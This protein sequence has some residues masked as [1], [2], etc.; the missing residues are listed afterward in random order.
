[1]TPLFKNRQNS[2]PKAPF[3]STLNWRDL[4]LFAP[5]A[6]AMT[7]MWW[8]PEGDKYAPA[9]ILAILVYFLVSRSWKAITGETQQ[10]LK[11]P[12]AATVIITALICAAGY[13]LKGG[14][15]SE[16]RTLSALGIF[17]GL[18]ICLTLTPRH[19][20]TAVL[21]SGAGFIAIC[22]YQFFIADMARVHLNYNPIPFATGLATVLISSLFLAITSRSL[23]V[24]Y[25]AW[26]S[27]LLLFIALAM[28]GTRGVAL[29]VTIILCGVTTYLLCKH[30]KSKKFAVAGILVTLILSIA[31]GGHI[32]EGRINATMTEMALIKSGDET[33]S[34]GLR[35]QFWKAAAAMATLE[36][37]TGLGEDHKSEFR[38]LAHQG[39]VNQA[40]TDYAPYHYHNQ[41]LDILVKRG[42]PGLLALLAL[43]TAPV[44][45]ALKYF[46]S[47]KLVLG[48]VCGIA[49][50]YT[51][52]SLTDVPF[53]HPT[54]INLYIL[55][56][57]ALLS[58]KL[59]NPELPD[60][61]ANNPLVTIQPAPSSTNFSFKPR[62]PLD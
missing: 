10:T 33:G 47:N 22:F 29:P 36:P 31:I 19:W 9:I 48:S 32:F 24:K 20:L 6:Y 23:K 2:M 25:V 53:N 55:S 1:M 35:L 34:I 43:L 52:A 3:N 18:S 16:L 44:L 40:A 59:E 12:L 57:T 30:A 41:F 38:N 39:L 37:V 11:L 56:M 42:I 17:S 8:I 27:T 45:I 46:R 51:V 60:Q 13:K 7:A 49:F 5:I 61:S 26:I 15:I 50:I 14:N 4:I 62:E 58:L 28:T 21:V 54:T